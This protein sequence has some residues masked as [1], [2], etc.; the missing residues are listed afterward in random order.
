MTRVRPALSASRRGVLKVIV[1]LGVARA[2]G[3]LAEPDSKTARPQPGDWLVRA[4]E[5]GRP[6]ALT[7]A[8]VPPGGP[9]V[10][11][12]PLDPTTGVVRDGSRLN[13]V[14][15]VHLEPADLAEET[16][17]RAA[18]G[19]VAYSS[20]C[21]HTGCDQWEWDA[22]A[23]TIK[24]SCH[25]STFDVKDAA[26]VLDGPAPRRLPALPLGTSGGD[27]VVAGAFVGRPGF[28]QGGA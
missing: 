11:A 5:G 23:K 27:L 2:T 4:G 7:P 17:A 26:R 10:I 18:A 19:V 13:Q 6:S 16:R 15:L 25:F 3:A 1:G 21:T 9:P 22:R 20:V 24:C 8:S 28:Q 14:L 12:Y